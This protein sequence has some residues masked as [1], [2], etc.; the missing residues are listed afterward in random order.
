[1][2]VRLEEVDGDECTI[3]SEIYA[4]LANHAGVGLCSAFSTQAMLE[5]K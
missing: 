5:L 4:E 2:G 3:V 1:V